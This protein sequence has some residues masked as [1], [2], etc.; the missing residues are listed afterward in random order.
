MK[1]IPIFHN[2]LAGYLMYKGFVLQALDISKN[3][4][5]RKMNLYIFNDSEQLQNAIS[6]F[7]GLQNK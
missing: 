6:E 2:K 7:K 3:S 4:A 5:D 1:K